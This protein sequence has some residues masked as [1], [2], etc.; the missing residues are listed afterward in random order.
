[1]GNKCIDSLHPYSLFTVRPHKL[2]HCPDASVLH[3]CPSACHQLTAAPSS[4]SHA[5]TQTCSKANTRARTHA[6]CCRTIPHT[7]VDC[8]HSPLLPPP[9]QSSLFSAD[10]ML[11]H[12]FHSLRCAPK[13]S[14]P[15]IFLTVHEFKLRLSSGPGRVGEKRFGGQNP[16]CVLA[17]TDCSVVV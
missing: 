5:N 15:A 2:L 14:K 3:F 16:A 11:A 17:A 6:H 4:R 8:I 12:T 13:K 1:M 10:V 7:H 9:P